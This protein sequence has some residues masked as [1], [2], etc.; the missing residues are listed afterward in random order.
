MVV[1]AQGIAVEAELGKLVGHEDGV[2][3]PKHAGKLTNP[4]E[5]PL[6]VR[7]TGVDM[8]AVTIG[9]VHG[10]YDTEP[11]LDLQRL[12]AIRAVTHVPLVLH[13]ASGL[14]TKAI[15]DSITRGV[16]KFNVN[17]DLRD[18]YV[19]ALKEEMAQQ[20]GKFDLLSGMKATT[21]A[22]QEVVRQKIKLFGWQ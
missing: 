9:N 7:E 18:A 16:C 20:D 5:V 13:G 19:Q 12:S 6:F 15:R 1:L 2:S 3:V 11:E 14:N 8:L 17:T 21:R 4:A 10:H 22:M